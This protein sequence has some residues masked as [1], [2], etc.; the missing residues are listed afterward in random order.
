MKYSSISILCAAL[1]AS[2]SAFVS[3]RTVAVAPIAHENGFCPTTTAATANQQCR[4]NY[5]FLKAAE[6]AAVEGVPAI[7]SQ[8]EEDS[9]D[10][11]IHDLLKIS[12][13]VYSFANVRSIVKENEGEQRSTSRWFG[14]KYTVAFD[15][16]ALILTQDGAQ[17]QSKDKLLKYVIT[18]DAI[19]LFM[20]LNR[21]W[22]KEPVTD[23][24]AGDWEFDKTVTEK[25]EPFLL[26][27]AVDAATKD[28][29]KIV[30]Y[31]SDKKSG[32]AT[33]C[34]YSFKLICGI[35]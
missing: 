32:G 34:F 27:A 28:N 2:A 9:L 1:T 24:N 17:E 7:K 19:K 26:E 14:E 10:V 13:F 8:S 33:C 30:D 22:F 18:P 25:T 20:E 16:P 23:G 35:S 11:V 21:K 3:P 4:S 12:D 6:E 29:M 15:T 31:V 5:S